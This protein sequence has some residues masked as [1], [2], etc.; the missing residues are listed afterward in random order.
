M[1]NSAMTFRQSMLVV[2]AFYA[3]PC[4]AQGNLGI[5]VYGLSYH[6]EREEA[7]RR[8]QDNEVNPGLGLRY[9]APGEK[10]D[11]FVDAAAYR[12]SA[13]N[14]ALYA[15]V[16]F[17]WKPTQGL[18]LGGAVALFHS[19]TYNDGDPFIAPVP[20][21][22]YEWRRVTLNVVYIPKIDSIDTLNTLG[23]WLT[24]WR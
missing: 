1:Q 9:R 22:G 14:T 17:F 13:R 20:L 16:G 6:F 21:A 3:G 24:F 19:D 15:G 7:E 8:G 23:F 5:N 11:A 4:A 10:F 2:L 18:R 12:D